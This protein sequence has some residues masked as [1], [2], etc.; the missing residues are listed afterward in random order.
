MAQ[1]DRRPPGQ[2]TY[3]IGDRLY[4]NLTD[5]CSLKCDFCLKNNS[6]GPFVEDVDLRLSR[7]PSATDIRKALT[8]LGPY[9]EVVFCGFGEPSLRLPTLLELAEFVQRK[10]KPV[11]L[12]TDGLANRVYRRDVTPQFAGRLDSVSVSLNAQDRETYNRLCKPPW[13]DA[14]DYVCDFIRKAKEYVPEVLVTAVDGVDGV[15]IEAC[16][17]LAENNLGVDFRAR[18][19]DRVG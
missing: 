4:I 16:R 14:F 17:S 12:D 19:R 7:Q 9:R 11:R 18:V 8:D 1:R 15:D 13:P 3:A 2:V 6:H 5:G 10:G